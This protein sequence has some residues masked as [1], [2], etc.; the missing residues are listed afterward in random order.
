[1]LV[2]QVLQLSYLACIIRYTG[3]AALFSFLGTTRVYSF[4][5]RTARSITQTFPSVL[6][7]AFPN[8]S[9]LRLPQSISFA[10]RATNFTIVSALHSDH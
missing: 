10:L 2:L 4:V 3:F 7:S 8:L 1:M 9:Y 6:S 5:A